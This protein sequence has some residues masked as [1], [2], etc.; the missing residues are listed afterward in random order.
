MVRRIIANFII[1]I[2]PKKIND[3]LTFSNNYKINEKLKY[4][5]LSYSQEGEDL[6]INRYFDGQEYG[7]YIDVGAHHPKRFSNTYFFYKRGWRGINI[8]PFPGIKSKFDTVRP[9][10]IN[11]ECGVDEK[12][13]V[14]DYY[15]F[16][17]PALNTFSL[18]EANLKNNKHGY[19]LVN[20]KQIP[21]DTLTNILDLNI[22]GN[23]EIDF[24]SIDVEGLDLRVL[25]SLDFSKYSPKMVL[26]EVL[27]TESIENFF[28]T[29][30]YNFMKNKNYNFYMKTFNTIF[31]VRN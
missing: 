24:L 13:S 8:D 6:L 10:D 22:P 16:N 21:V 26:V 14:L 9:F 19:F 5:Q 1:F 27:L 23:I 17:E 12:K 11:I 7:F 30:I 3:I 15:M 28:T 4:A 20:K 29:D 31:F 18:E 2:T 25:K